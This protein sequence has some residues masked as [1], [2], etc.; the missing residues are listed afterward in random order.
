MNRWHK[1]QLAKIGG[2]LCED[3]SCERGRRLKRAVWSADA[4]TV[5]DE[6]EAV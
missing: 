3:M 6:R 5:R 1:D 2:V 4:A